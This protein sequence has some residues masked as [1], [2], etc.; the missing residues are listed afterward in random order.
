[1]FNYR[2]DPETSTRD[3]IALNFDAVHGPFI[4][5][6]VGDDYD[7]LV[8]VGEPEEPEIE[9]PEEPEEPDEDATPEARAE[10][11]KA[12][13]LYLAEQAEYEKEWDAYNE[14]RET[15]EN[16]HGFPVAWNRMWSSCETLRSRV[17]SALLASGFVVYDVSE[18]EVDFGFN[19]VF[20][21]D[22]G[23]YDF[24]E[25]HWRPL[26]AR[27][28]LAMLYRFKSRASAVRHN[29]LVQFLAREESP[30]RVDERFIAKFS[31]DPND[32]VQPY[33][34]E[35]DNAQLV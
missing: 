9:E 2:N 1:M 17:Q 19:F 12:M 7:Q 24:Y 30:S 28:S 8:R 26:R 34:K 21:V 27:C 35:E 33:E 14:A 6:A 32:F 5:A 29:A 4:A 11:D 20:G 3:W 18:S 31:V 16:P 23:G 15:W 22:G 13:V 25:A 10:Y